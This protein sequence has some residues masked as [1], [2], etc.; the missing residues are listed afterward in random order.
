MNNINCLFLLLTV[1]YYLSHLLVAINC[2][3]YSVLAST[4]SGFDVWGYVAIILTLIGVVAGIAAI[5]Y[6]CLFYPT[7]CMKKRIYEELELPLFEDM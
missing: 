5:Y 3:T 6:F 2:V 1:Q 4:G 7:L